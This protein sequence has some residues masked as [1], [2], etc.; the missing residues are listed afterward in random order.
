MK[1]TTLN[2]QGFKDWERRSDALVHHLRDTDPDI[3]FFQEVVY[4]PGISPYNQP[5]LL[6]QTLGYPYELS[7]ITRLQPSD[8]YSV[9]REGL[10]TLS[11]YPILKSDT[12]ILQQA[13]G[14]EHN[15][16]VQLL[17]LQ[18]DEKVVKFANVHFSITDFYDYATPHLEELLNILASRGEERIIGGD[19]NLTHLENSQKL[20]GD[21]YEATLEP[22]Y[23]TFPSWGKRVDYFLV[24]KTRR[25]TDLTVSE[26]G[27]SDHRSLTIT[28][29]Q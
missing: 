13:E 2:L 26:D 29:S 25:F 3:I 27:L 4:L 20:W 24:P 17:D 15:R 18:I 19:F 6:N 21:Q 10:T 11:K 14:D 16:I 12:I 1:L 23:I 7:T 28:I 8:E 22:Q 9:Y 5:Q